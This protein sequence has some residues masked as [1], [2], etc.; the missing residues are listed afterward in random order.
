MY[1]NKEYYRKIFTNNGGTS[2]YISKSGKCISKKKN[3]H[4]LKVYITDH[5][6]EY[7][8][9]SNVIDGKKKTTAKFL[10]RLVAEAYIPNPEHK[11]EVNHKDG[12]KSNNALNNLEWVTSYENKKHAK[13]NN[14]VHYSK[15]EDSGRAK[16][17]NN[18]IEKACKLMEKNKL[19]LIEISKKTGVDIDTLYQIRSHRNIWYSISN[20]YT[21]PNKPINPNIKISDKM[22]RKICKLIVKGMSNKEISNLT[23]VN[24]STVRDI[25]VRRIRKNISND[26][27]F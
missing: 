11:P 6:Y 2:Y 13:E 9:F 7:V 5:G 23:G 4:E 20:K 10:H 22:V 8:K 17:L 15:G 16:Y 24:I 19:P 3:I 26:Y 12:N 14:L 25:R 18:E 21:F 1:Y 27:D